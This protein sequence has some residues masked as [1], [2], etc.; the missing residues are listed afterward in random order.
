MSVKLNNKEIGR[1]TYPNGERMFDDI[2]LNIRQNGDTANVFVQYQH[3][4]DFETFSLLASYINTLPDV[5]SKTLDMWY[6]PYLRMDRQVGSKD[7]MIKGITHL[8]AT[9]CKDWRIRTLDPH[10][11]IN[12]GWTDGLENI[13]YIPIQPFID[14]IT[15]R[16][17]VDMV[18][19]PDKGALEKYSELLNISL[20][21]VSARK[22]RDTNTGQIIKIALDERAQVNGGTVLIIDDICSYGG[23]ANAVAQQLITRGAER[24]V[25]WFSHTETSIKKGRI[26]LDH[27]MDHVYTSNSIRDDA[28]NPLMTILTLNDHNK[29][30]ILQRMEGENI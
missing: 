1:D 25:A 3:S 17:Q 15:K 21:V 5:N 23:T 28:I 2:A 14:F 26:F 13:E 19:F 22:E 27:H 4:D 30:E 12:T 8:L 10:P 29:V 24:V 20:P 18:C 6:I 11:S 7:P 9:L 16:E